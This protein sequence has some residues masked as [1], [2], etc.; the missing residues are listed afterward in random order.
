MVFSIIL[1]YFLAI[2]SCFCC[3]VMVKHWMTLTGL[4]LGAHLFGGLI[5]NLTHNKWG[6]GICGYIWPI[7]ALSKYHFPLTGHKVYQ[8]NLRPWD[9]NLACLFTP[10]SLPTK[11]V[12]HIKLSRYLKEHYWIS[13]SHG[14]SR[15]I[16]TFFKINN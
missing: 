10:L 2:R 1:F 16:H 14:T 4:Y 9:T 6:R 5:P 13:R 11:L 15:T 12:R 7:C 8:T 3:A